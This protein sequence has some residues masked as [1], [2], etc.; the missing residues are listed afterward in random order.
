MWI[1]YALG[2]AFFAGITTVFAKMGIKST[3]SNVA[4]AIRTIIVV[5]FSWL[6]VGLVGSFNQISTIESKTLLFLVLSGLST[7]IS[8]LFYFK[9]LQV[10]NINK[11][12]AVDK[13]S[14]VLTIILSLIIFNEQVTIYKIVGMV[15]ITVGTYLMIQKKKIKI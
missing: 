12:V 11:V 8:W 14:I 13:S 9:A 15:F 7:G 1:I 4:T 5:I 3:D 2:S 10:G 6:M